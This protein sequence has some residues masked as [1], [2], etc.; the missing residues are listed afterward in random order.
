MLAKAHQADCGN[1]LP[2]TYI[3][4]ARNVYD[5]GALIFPC[6]KVQRDYRDART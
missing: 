6:V 2:T 5:E 3:A 4:E 1:A